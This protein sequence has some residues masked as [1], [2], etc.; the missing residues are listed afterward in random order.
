MWALALRCMACAAG[1]CRVLGGGG[2]D[3]DEHG[4]EAGDL[5]DVL[6]AYRV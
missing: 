5:S 4:E 2:G 1:L 6:G 3:G